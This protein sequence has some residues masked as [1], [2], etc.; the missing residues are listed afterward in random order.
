MDWFP[1]YLPAG[2]RAVL[3]TTPDSPCLT[4]LSK[5]DPR[6]VCVRVCVH[7]CARV[8]E[9]LHTC[10]WLYPKN[11]MCDTEALLQVFDT[12]CVLHFRYCTVCDNFASRPRHLFHMFYF[13]SH[14]W[15]S[16]AC[17]KLSARRLL[18]SSCVSTASALHASSLNYCLPRPRA[19]SRC[20]YSLVA[21]SCGA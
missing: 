16:R 4:A 15:T 14:N 19:T 10:C 12:L 5:R 21:R 17:R 20:T 11:T 18:F 1:T 13:R 7:V 2:I 8:S 6:P 9:F 3:S